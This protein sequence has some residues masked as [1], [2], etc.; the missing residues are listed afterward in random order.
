MI[1]F[2][3]N[4]N[5]I[6]TLQKHIDYT[7]EVSAEQLKN[8]Q[9]EYTDNPKR[10]NDCDFIIVTVPTPIDNAN[11]PDLTPLIKATEMVG[12]NLQKGAVVVYESTVYPGATEEVCIPILEKKSGLKA[13]EGF[14]VGY[15]PDKLI[16]GKRNT[17]SKIL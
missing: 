7:G 12:E 2:D 4:P 14:S 9:I 13:G 8:T 15:S 11:N 1:G 6:Q 16:L 10:I 3:I 5:R 17:T